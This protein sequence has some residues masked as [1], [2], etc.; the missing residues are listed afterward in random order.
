MLPEWSRFSLH[1]QLARAL[2]AQHFTRP[3]PIQ[4]EAL[5]LALAGRDVV[6]VAETVCL[7]IINF[8]G[9]TSP[10]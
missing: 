4:A 8:R 7:S 5:P 10:L 3:T 1:D 6:G 2:Y 9:A